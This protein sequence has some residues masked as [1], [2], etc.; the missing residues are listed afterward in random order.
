MILTLLDAVAG[1][2]QVARMHFFDTGGHAQEQM[3]A[4]EM[5]RRVNDSDKRRKGG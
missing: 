4:R 1:G 3:T 5:T 2:V